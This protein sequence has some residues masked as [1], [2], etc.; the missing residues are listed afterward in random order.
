MCYMDKNSLAV[1]IEEKLMVLLETNLKM[2]PKTDRSGVG[3]D[4][5][6]ISGVTPQGLANK[7]YNKCSH[8]L[9]FPHHFDSVR[10]F[11]RLQLET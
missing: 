3:I 2:A 11:S 6:Q 8:Q 10:D 4:D 9:I 5:L 1:H 7:G